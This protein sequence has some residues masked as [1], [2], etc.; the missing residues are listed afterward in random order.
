[1]AYKSYYKPY[2][3]LQN[4]DYHY[5]SI[6]AVDLSIYNKMLYEMQNI[7]HMSFEETLKA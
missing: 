7:T 2:T 5:M 3:I 1:M 4:D 6:P